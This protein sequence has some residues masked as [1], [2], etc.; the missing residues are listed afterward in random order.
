MWV[1]SAKAISKKILAPRLR[2][3]ITPVGRLFDFRLKTRRASETDYVAEFDHPG[4]KKART[5]ILWHD[6]WDKA[7]EATLRLFRDLDLTEGGQ[8][9]IDYGCGI[10]RISKALAE[11]FQLGALL[12]VDRSAE[13]LRHARSYLPEQ[14]LKEG[15]IELLTDA[16]LLEKLVSLTAKVDVILFIEVLHHIP[17]P[18]LDDLMIKLLPALRPDGRLFVLG[19]EVLDVDSQG[20]FNHKSIEEFLARHLDITRRDLWSEVL[21]GDT[22]WQFHTPRHSFVCRARASEPEHQSVSAKI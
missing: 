20:K 21:V 19:N 22:W 17:E 3:R 11:N 9:I 16:E 8:I 1:T 6:D 7:T 2:Q 18:I 15:K 14:Q 10:G 5:S 13:M 4:L 12:A